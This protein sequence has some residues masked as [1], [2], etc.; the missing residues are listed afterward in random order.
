MR[1]ESLV[2]KRIVFAM[3]VVAGL[4]GISC[5]QHFVRLNYSCYD[6]D[7]RLNE[8]WAAL[9]EARTA[10][11]D[12]LPNGIDRCDNLR[13]QIEYIAQDCP[14]DIH[15]LMINAILAYDEKQFAKSEQLLDSLFSLRTNYPEAAILK[16][17]L[18]LEEGNTPFALRYL[19]QQIQLSPDHAGLRELYASALY[20]V[21]RLEEAQAALTMAQ[22]LGG[23][24][25]RINYGRGLIQEAMGQLA[26]ARIYYEAA[27]T[28]RP[29]WK[30][31]ESR[32]RALDAA[33]GSTPQ[34]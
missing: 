26:A 17:R 15:A 11:C 10:G 1:V 16:A 9:Q 33:G 24:S 23:P 18:A 8:T 2:R 5:S 22:R 34:R 25:W 29:G 4:I 14:N 6:A 20:S 32:L 3:V 30:P 27:L 7:S 19:E 31:P 21:T 28:E 13:Q 12:V